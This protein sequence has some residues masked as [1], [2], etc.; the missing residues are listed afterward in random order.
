MNIYQLL[1]LLSTTTASPL[2]LVD[3]ASL[4]EF[5]DFQ[6]D[7]VSNDETVAVSNNDP[8]LV[9][10]TQAPIP[11]ISTSQDTGPPI[12]DSWLD[13]VQ[14]EPSFPFSSSDLAGSR[15]EMTQNSP[16]AEKIA[17][18]GERTTDAVYLCCEFKGENK[19]LCDDRER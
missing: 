14:V 5:T 6:H 16:A 13:T 18:V 4:P 17:P 19:F 8:G 1:T 2:L 10:Q 7:P 9:G 11:G 3:S 15:F 12:I